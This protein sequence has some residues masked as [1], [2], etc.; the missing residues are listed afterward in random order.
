MLLFGQNFSGKTSFIRSVG[1]CIIL[2]QAGL[3]VPATE[4]NFT[5]F[6]K[7][8]TKIS[9]G[10]NL[11]RNQSTYTN[12]AKE[13]KNMIET[14]D[15]NTLILADEL[16]SGT[17]IP[18]ALSLVSSTVIFLD[19][20]K[21]R[22]I[23]TTHFHELLDIHEIKEINSFQIYHMKTTITDGKIIFNRNLEKGKCEDN[24]GIEI[25]QHMK[26]PT[27]FIHTATKIRNRI[28]SSTEIISSKTSKY[29]KEIYMTECKLCKSTKNLHTHHIIFQSVNP[30]EGKNFKNNL[31][32]LCQDCHEKLH[33]NEIQIN[34][35]LETSE[36]IEI[37]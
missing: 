31:V 32:V 15:Q 9:L 6:T 37:I 16:C 3:P 5:P 29:N 24:Y 34:K 17:E 12:E 20:I 25:A 2:A 13:I 27:E 22:Y 36:G 1:I 4:M 28:K 18:S 8:I 11:K 7:L 33:K 23:F 19:K 35:I 10:D 30:G 14:G 21:A 26:L